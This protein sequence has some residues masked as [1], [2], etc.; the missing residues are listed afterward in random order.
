M[1]K[2]NSLFQSSITVAIDCTELL[3]KQFSV[4]IM[5]I[6]RKYI[7]I[8]L[9]LFPFALWKGSF[10][11]FTADTIL[12]GASSWDSKAWASSW[13]VVG[14]R[15][16][17]FEVY[18]WCRKHGREFEEA[19]GRDR[20]EWW[21]VKVGLYLLFVFYFYADHEGIALR[22]S[23]PISGSLSASFSLILPSFWTRSLPN[24]NYHRKHFYFLSLLFAQCAL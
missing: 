12:R 22:E 6:Y 21:P 19:S 9:S 10:K 15:T 17:A 2:A 7:A 14:K 8:A 13:G 4:T 1:R 23:E 16:I 11:G 24:Q 3:R 18:C 5:W 20:L